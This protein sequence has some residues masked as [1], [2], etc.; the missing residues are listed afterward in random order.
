MNL[1]GR[2]LIAF[3]ALIVLV[4]PSI[5]AA[6]PVCG[7]DKFDS[8]LSLCAIAALATAGVI[9]LAY[10]FGEFFQN[11]RV[12]TWAKTEVL[13]VFASLIIA[14]V[15]IEL[16][17]VFCT[18]Q[19]GEVGKVFTALPAVYVQHKDATMYDAAEIYLENLMAIT[20][21][22]MQ[23][24]RFSLGAYE[25]RTTY[26]T[27]ECDSA[28][29]LTMV[30]FNMGEYGGES[31]KLAVTNNLLGT[32]T[33][34]Y[35]SAVFQYFTLQYIYNGLFLVFLPISIALRAAPFMRQ[36]AGA[37]VAIFVTLY[38]LYPLLLVF[39][40]SIASGM[41]SGTVDMYRSQGCEPGSN[42]Y[43]REGTAS[44]IHCDTNPNYNEENMDLGFWDV[45]T[46]SMPDPAPIENQ[47]RASALIF[48][49]AVF[50]PALNF[51]VMAAMA[52]G[53]SHIIGED[54]DISRLGQMI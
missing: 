12:I 46:G 32:A 16:V 30:G 2:R 15:A 31:L 11:P 34:A 47:A 10:M 27:M 3:A 41:A 28:C 14:A 51:I 17:S 9:T 53:I 40:A 21:T 49:T 25:I 38:V 52:R 43:A 5:A 45:L 50:L 39:N 8:V 6:A 18:L 29:F 26:T 20:H 7:S 24:I 4:L 48:I 54:V 13:Q 19:I 33:V 37:L 42:V 22:N 23:S 1:P 35:L 44:T 36:F